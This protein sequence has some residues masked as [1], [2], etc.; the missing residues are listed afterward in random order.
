MRLLFLLLLGTLGRSAAAA[1]SDNDDDD[2][3]AILYRCQGHSQ[4][5]GK[6]WNSESDAISG[7]EYNDSTFAASAA[8]ATKVDQLDH[9]AAWLMTLILDTLLVDSDNIRVL[10][11]THRWCQEPSVERDELENKGARNIHSRQLYFG[12]KGVSGGSSYSGSASYGKG[13]SMS[14]GGKGGST[15]SGGKGGSMSSSGKG[16]SMS[17]SG[18]GGSKSSSGKGGSKSHGGTGKG[19]GKGYQSTLTPDDD[20]DDYYYG[21]K[22]RHG[23]YSWHVKGSVWGMAAIWIQVVVRN[24]F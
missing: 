20:E 23:A 10:P 17:S 1:V 5:H 8:A 9:D 18:K 22:V 12:G 15:S 3:D 24:V 13:G 7:E 4:V 16:G 6:L 19:T 14:S 2:D 11:Q 21:G